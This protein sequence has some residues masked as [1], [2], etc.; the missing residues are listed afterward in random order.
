MTIVPGNQEVLQWYHYSIPNITIFKDSALTIIV[1]FVIL[2]YT[3]KA[4]VK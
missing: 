4:N 1:M 3:C 2:I